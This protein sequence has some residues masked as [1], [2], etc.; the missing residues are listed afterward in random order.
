M[1][2]RHRIWTHIGLLWMTGLALA[3][4]M[5]P[6]YTRGQSSAHRAPARGM[7]LAASASIISPYDYGKVTEEQ[8][9]AIAAQ[10]VVRVGLLLPLTGRSS[11]LGRALQ[12][13]ATVSLFDKYARLSVNQQTVRVELLPKDTGDTP[14]QAAA[15]AQAA[16][17][18]GAQFIIGPLFA[19][20][21]AAVAPIA[22]AANIQV[23]S[24]SNTRTQAGVNTYMFGF[25]PQ[26]QTERIVSFAITNNRKRI[27]VLAPSTPL[28]DTVVTA[29][30]EAALKMDVKLITEARYLVQGSGMDTALNTLVPKGQELTFDTL[31][32]PEGGAALDTIMRGLSARGVK[33]STVQFIGTGIWDDIT[34]LRRVNLDGAWFASSPPEQTTQFELRFRSTYNYTPP[35]IASLAY[36]AVA[37][38]VTLATSGRPFDAVTL[39]NTSGFAGPANG[40]FRL[41][42]N[43]I[44]QRGLAV[45]KVEGASPRMIAPPPKGF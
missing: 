24:F 5:A 9:R 36:D 30:R 33:P 19:D 12:D 29:A 34:L 2:N 13:A 15:A 4:C 38:T 8:S 22:R 37:L 40:I 16:I 11:D 44:V 42:G 1:T 14:E 35:R 17:R 6:E 43:G 20:A 41:R 27:A 7:E 45:M 10:K 28:G 25:S 32:L 31:L 3:S 18:D 23:L 26:E 21:T 39:T